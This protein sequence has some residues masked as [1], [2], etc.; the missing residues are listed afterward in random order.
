MENKIYYTIADHE[1]VWLLDS[2]YISEL[3]FLM[4]K[5]YQEEKKLFMTVNLGL[6][7]ELIAGTKPFSP[8]II[9]RDRNL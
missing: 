6:F 2:T 8:T 9:S 5:F 7:D 1:G 4:A 3:G